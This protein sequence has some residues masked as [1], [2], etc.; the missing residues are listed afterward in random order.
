LI[1]TYLT[2]YPRVKG[3]AQSLILGAEMVHAII[4]N[5]PL[6]MIGGGMGGFGGGGGM[7]G[8]GGYGQPAGFQF[9]SQGAYGMHS[10]MM[11][12][13]QQFGFGGM[14]AGMNQPMQMQ[15]LQMQYGGFGGGSTSP[16]ALG[17]KYIA[18]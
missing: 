5:Q 10:G 17:L 4:N 16:I 6:H 14:A 12:M 13:G 1:S 8:M 3:P 15:A 18:K 11:P 7:G 2:E 9:P